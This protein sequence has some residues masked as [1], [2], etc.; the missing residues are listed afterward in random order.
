M[1]QMRRNVP[2]LELCLPV[3]KQM[4]REQARGNNVRLKP[5][6]K[7]QK[8]T[9]HPL[10]LHLFHQAAQGYSQHYLSYSAQAMDE[11]SDYVD[12][13]SQHWAS[14][15]CATLRMYDQA[16]RENAYLQTLTFAE[17][18]ETQELW[19][20]IVMPDLLRV[21]ASPQTFG[22]RSDRTGG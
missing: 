4:E 9:L 18:T 19:F 12:R 20:R 6:S 3:Y 2:A 11:F 5:R 17:A 13:L 14:V 22:G 15:P 21:A 16:V 7:C 1:G 8:Y 10:D